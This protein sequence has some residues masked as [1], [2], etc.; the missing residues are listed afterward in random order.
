M[1]IRVGLIGCGYWGPN[2]IRNF[3]KNEDSE[4]VLAADLDR[5]RLQAIQRPFPSLQTTTSTGRVLEDDSI[6]A[7]VIATPISTHFS[8][9][10][11]ALMRG[12]HVLVEKPLTETASQ[13]EELVR[14]ADRAG[15]VLMVDHTFIYTGAVGKI[16]ELIDCGELGEIY[17]YDSVRVNLGLFRS[18]V[19]VIWDLAPHDFS[20]MLHLLGKKP[21]RVT[22]TGSA[23]V[24]W[25]NW[26]LE[27]IAYVSIEFEDRTLA[28]F[29]INWL[30]PVK[31]RKTLIGGSRKMVIYDPLD[32]D[33]EVKVFDKGVEV[34]SQTH[35]HRT[36]VQYR[37]GDILLPKIDQTEALESVCNHFVSCIRTG[38]RPLTDGSSGL[39]VVRLLEA[40]QCAMETGKP[41]DYEFFT[42]H[43]E[44]FR[45]RTIA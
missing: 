1:T 4:L 7:V 27:S 16:K 20:L 31:V 34:H 15:K 23:P 36:L 24:R 38:R 2:L 25:P 28:H 40:A 8:L 29:H 11:E 30:S 41:V 18:D 14:L 10:K 5:N 22:A 12:K 45:R 26:N 19:N 17:Y 21:V 44:L 42:N 33:N 35:R 32:P 3:F 6:D 39:E 37:T 13:S 43:H 9:A